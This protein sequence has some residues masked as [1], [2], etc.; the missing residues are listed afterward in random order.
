VTQLAIGSN[1]LQGVS[2]VSE[3]LC[4]A[5]DNA[6]NVVSSG[7]PAAG[8]GNVWRSAHVDGSGLDAVSCPSLVLC[9]AVDEAGD[10]LTSTDPKGGAQTWSAADV[11]GAIALTGISC[12]TEHLC[13]AIDKEGDVVTSADPTGGVGAWNV[14]RLYPRLG[15][16][17]CPSEHLCVLTGG[18][19]IITSSEP[20]GGAATWS[21]RN[22]DANYQI[23]CASVSLC[24]SVT[25][26]FVP[27]MTWGDPTSS[28][29][30]SRAD[31]EELNGLD[32]VSCAPGGLCV[33]TAMGGMGTPGDAIATTEP[34]GGVQAWSQGNLYGMPSAPPPNDGIASYYIEEMP[35][36]SCVPEGMCVVVTETGRAIVGTPP[37]PVP[38]A[39]GESS[40]PSAETSVGGSS[41]GGSGGSGSGGSG[42]GG[43]QGAVAGIVSD[44]F[45]LG[46]ESVAAHGTLRLRLTVPA[47]GVL[48]IVGDASTARLAAAGRRKRQGRSFV[49]A[50]LRLAVSKP[51]P[52]VVTLA[53]TPLARTILA[54]RGKLTTTL[55]IT[56][57]PHGGKPRSIERTVTFKLK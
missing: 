40:A 42:V 48:Q 38:P 9:V 28:S 7:D 24:V 39:S 54:R 32:V 52:I 14:V 22:V 29:V 15:G 2:C 37:P 31:F 11:D 25:D 46:I 26:G 17:S 13:V 55:T 16:V 49:A 51:G 34:A 43:G 5:V 56:Y 50:R 1:V 18:G 33:A 44:S 8:P 10:V 23:S 20:A 30:W 21:L 35:G 4:V 19:N 6:G 53:P 12:A 36:V 3:A 47:S 41:P 27:G 45:A 57:P